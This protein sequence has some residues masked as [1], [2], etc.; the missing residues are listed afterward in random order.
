MHKSSDSLAQ[1]DQAYWLEQ[2]K[3]TTATAAYFAGPL[4]PEAKIFLPVIRGAF[5]GGRDQG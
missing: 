5:V 4:A 1:I 2:M 3:V